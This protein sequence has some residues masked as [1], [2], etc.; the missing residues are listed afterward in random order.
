[1]CEFLCAGVFSPMEALL[2]MYFGLP[3]RSRFIAGVIAFSNFDVFFSESLCYS[4][5]VHFLISVQFDV[6]DN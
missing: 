4:A 6:I 2:L 5:H 3:I 1:M